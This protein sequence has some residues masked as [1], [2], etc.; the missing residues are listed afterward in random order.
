M[1]RSGYNL[2]VRSGYNLMGRMKMDRIIKEF[3]LSKRDASFTHKTYFTDSGYYNP[4]R[5]IIGY[6]CNVAE[7]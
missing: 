4:N 2:M 7:V 5:K 6:N 1:V 3:P